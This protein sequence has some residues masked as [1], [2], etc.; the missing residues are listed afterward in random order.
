MKVCAVVPTW[1]ARATTLE[2][3]GSI[4]RSTTRAT[5]IVVDNGSR[6]G[7]AGAVRASFPDALVIELPENVGFAR[8]VNRGITRALDVGADAVLLLNNDARLDPPALARLVAA[9]EADPTA[10]LVAPLVLDEPEGRIWWAGGSFSRRLA[11]VR[12]ERRKERLA[13]GELEG[14]PPRRTDFAPLTAALLARRAIERVGLLDERFFLYFE[15]VDLALRLHAAGLAILHV[16]A[17]RARHEVGLTARRRQVDR[18]AHE[19]RSLLLL[20]RKHL[21]A[22][23]LATAIPALFFHHVLG[24]FALALARREP[25][26]VVGMLKGAAWYLTGRYARRS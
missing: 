10:G 1:D 3:L 24:H 8:A 14:A 19:T 5:P 20:V 21:R 11:R 18:F 2:C 7:T 16:P 13:P 12:H 22:T 15:D 25:A 4:A 6:D 23:E 26:F 9:L 17:A